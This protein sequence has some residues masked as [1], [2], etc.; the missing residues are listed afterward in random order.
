MPIWMRCGPDMVDNRINSTA[1]SNLNRSCFFV[2][3]YELIYSVFWFRRR[4]RHTND[5]FLLLIFHSVG[6]PCKSYL[7]RVEE[8]GKKREKQWVSWNECVA[9]HG[10]SSGTPFHFIF[11]NFIL[12]KLRL[13]VNILCCFWSRH[14]HRVPGK[15]KNVCE[16]CVEIN[17]ATTFRNIDFEKQKCDANR[18]LCCHCPHPKCMTAT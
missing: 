10:R 1:H 5:Y 9:L 18:T 15:N 14:K 6:C 4:L 11:F 17:F 13:F 12:F 3:Q 7:N 8:K 16:G 2:C